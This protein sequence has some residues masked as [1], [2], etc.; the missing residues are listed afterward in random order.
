[1]EKIVE[2]GSRA[3]LG[4]NGLEK[5]LGR[6]AQNVAGGECLAERHGDGI[7]V[8]HDFLAG[9]TEVVENGVDEGGVVG[10]KYSER[11]AGFVAEARAGEGD[12]KVAGFLVGAFGGERM[13]DGKR[14]AEWILAR[15][16]GIG[17]RHGPVE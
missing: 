10:R 13:V 12:F 17:R 6:F 11:I 5:L 7:G 16:D 14:S 15:V 8:W 4:S 9:E 2:K 1:M 3:V